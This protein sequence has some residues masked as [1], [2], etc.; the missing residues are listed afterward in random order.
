MNHKAVID[1][2]IGAGFKLNVKMTGNGEMEL[3][4]VDCHIANQRYLHRH[5]NGFQSDRSIQCEIHGIRGL[6]VILDRITGINPE[7]SRVTNKGHT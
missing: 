5:R 6:I 1:G 7:K 4:A 3:R 2:N